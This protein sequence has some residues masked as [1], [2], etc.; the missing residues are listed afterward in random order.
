MEGT[1]HSHKCR[2]QNRTSTRCPQTYTSHETQMGKRMHILIHHA[3]ICRP[4]TRAFTNLLHSHKCVRDLAQMCNAYLCVCMLV[5]GV[6]VFVL[7]CVCM[8]VTQV[9]TQKGWVHKQRQ[10]RGRDSDK[11]LGPQI[12]PRKTKTFIF[13]NILTGLLACYII[14]SPLSSLHTQTQMHTHEFICLSGLV[15]PA[16]NPSYSRC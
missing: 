15:L 16:C 11:L 8:V 9:Y 14:Q 5:S 2:C 6:F 3:L 4:N 1:P 7:L 12:S 10:K 13:Q